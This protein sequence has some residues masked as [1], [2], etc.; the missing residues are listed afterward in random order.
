MTAWR[1]SWEKSLADD[2]QEI[3]RAAAAAERA[4]QEAGK[5][6]PYRPHW[7][8]Q[9][10]LR[11]IEHHPRLA[12]IWLIS[13]PGARG[14]FECAEK[15]GRLLASYQRGHLERFHKPVDFEDFDA[16]VS[17]IRG[18]LTSEL[19]GLPAVKIAV[20]ITGGQKVASIVSAALTMNRELRFQYVQTNHPFEAV[21]YQLVF[22]NP[23]SPHGH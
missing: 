4:A 12:H 18:L 1:G 8:W 17:A 2:I 10:L 15:C 19:R 3:S 23:P 13:S 6:L 20:D 9:P 7:N 14:S 11:A 5:P 16:L 21:T 22:D